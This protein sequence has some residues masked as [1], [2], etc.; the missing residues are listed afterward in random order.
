[1]FTTEGTREYRLQMQ[2]LVGL[3]VAAALTV[4]IGWLIT[5]DSAEHE[6]ITA[7]IAAPSDP[8][9][10]RRPLRHEAMR[11]RALLLSDRQ[12]KATTAFD[13][14]DRL[15]LGSERT[16]K[17]AGLAETLTRIRGL[18]WNRE[19]KLWLAPD[20]IAAA[21]ALAAGRSGAA[22]AR[23]LGG[24]KILAVD[25]ATV[26]KGLNLADEDRDALL[27]LL[28]GQPS[29]MAAPLVEG[30]LDRGLA[31]ASIH[32]RSLEGREGWML[33]DNGSDYR[34]EPRP[35]LGSLVR[36]TGPG[37]PEQWLVLHIAAQPKSTP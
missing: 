3:V 35:F 15:R 2:W 24:S 10:R 11:Q 16:I 21:Q 1:V 30:W 25:A 28:T 8:A 29:A 4:L 19:L 6:A 26:A 33:I 23:I 20:Q 7:Y 12:G 5:M 18:R 17:T 22:L 14:L 37:W 13:T 9:Q 27:D 31:P 36:F 32:L 34:R